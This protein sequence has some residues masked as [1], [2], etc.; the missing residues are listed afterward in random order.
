VK[1]R[2]GLESLKTPPVP[3]S[4]MT[5]LDWYAGMA[6]IGCKLVTQELAA[7]WAMDRAEAVMAERTKRGL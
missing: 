2:E 6:L 5:L 4:E 1:K 3:M 7:E